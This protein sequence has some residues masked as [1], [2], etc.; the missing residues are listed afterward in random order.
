[1]DHSK[2]DTTPLLFVA[3]LAVGAGVTALLTPR[4]GNEVRKSILEGAEHVK[5]SLRRVSEDAKDTVQ[6]KADK[7]KVVAQKTADRLS[8]L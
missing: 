4:R 3:G 7:S 8:E 5:G 1:M 6:D 2:S